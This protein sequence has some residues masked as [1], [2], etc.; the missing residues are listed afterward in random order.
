MGLRL[1]IYDRTCH[2][3]PLRPGLSFAWKTGGWLYRSLGRIDAMRGVESWGEALKWLSTQQSEAPIDEVQYW[4]H[5][6]WGSA[7]VRE[8]VL[9]IHALRPGHLLHPHLLQ[10]RSRLH[11]D[12]L[13][14]FRT[15][16][17][18]GAD[19]GHAFARGF[20]DFLGCAM[21]GHT[22]IIGYY[23]SGLHRLRPGQAPHWPSE[24]GLACGTPAA[25]EEALWSKRSLPH[26]ISCLQ[27]RIPEAT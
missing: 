2:G 12:S 20:T 26:T 21:A 15:C 27:G 19:A 1:L 16:E 11:A 22:H 17:T 10:L 9:D 8:E 13:W 24:E 5:G 23:Q 18:F 4:G 6:K 14:W 3:R 7:R 25:P